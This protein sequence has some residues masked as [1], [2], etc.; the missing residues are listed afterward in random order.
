MNGPEKVRGDRRNHR[1]NAEQLGG[2][3]QNLG[4]IERH[5]PI[6]RL[7][8]LVHRRL[9]VDQGDRVVLRGEQVEL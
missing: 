7:D 4:I 1:R 8:A 9:E 3:C 2:L 6:V 5:Q